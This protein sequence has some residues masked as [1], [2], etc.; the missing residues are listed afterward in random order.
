[1]YAYNQN[2][3]Q[4]NLDDIL[5]I[6]SLYGKP[7]R[8][9]LNEGDEHPTPS[10]PQ[11]VPELCHLDNVNTFLIVNQLLY[12]FYGKWLWISDLQNSTSYK[13]TAPQLITEWLNFLP[14]DFKTIS[15]IYQ[16]PSGE[17]VMIVH[18]KIYM[19]NYPTFML[20]KGYPISLS[21]WNIRP[22]TVIHTLLNT[23]SGHT[24]I[25]YNDVFFTEIDECSFK[26]KQHGILSR[27]FPGLPPAMDSS[28]RYI[29]GMLY[30]FKGRQVY[31]YNE[32][33]N[34]LIKAEKFD[35]S[36]IGI[37]CPKRSSTFMDIINILKSTVAQPDEMK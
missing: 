33:M 35:L 17:I 7:S 23:Y 19:I 27:T 4:L 37:D 16:R 8:E 34:S 12:I 14:N 6:Q 11:D 25:F 2:Q 21:E 5:A 24:Y 20:V 32:F 31:Q 3:I 1:M 26:P 9:K 10:T 15:A 30:F 28:F 13:S 22:N 29:N 36:M 18:N